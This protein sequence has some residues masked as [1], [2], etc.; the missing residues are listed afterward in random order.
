M[1]QSVKHLTSAQVMISWSVTSSP[2]S[3]SVLT[4]QPASDSVSPSLWPIPNP[5]LSLS[6]TLPLSKINIKTFLKRKVT[7]FVIKP[8][9]CVSS[10]QICFKHLWQ[11]LL[12]LFEILL[13]APELEE[14][15]CSSFLAWAVVQ[16]WGCGDYWEDTCD[17][18]C[19][20]D[21]PSGVYTVDLWRM[22]VSYVR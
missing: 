16:L 7:H 21:S 13:E 11:Q 1:A 3:G 8:I 5:T 6:L 12:C 9:I 19:Q 15:P 22:Y 17:V 14:V 4:A 18:K 2:T 20:P 10:V